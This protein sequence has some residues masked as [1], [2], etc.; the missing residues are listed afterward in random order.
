LAE[1]KK[2]GDAAATAKDSAQGEWATLLREFL[3][4][5]LLLRDVFGYALPGG[6]LVFLFVHAYGERL[7]SP[8]HG[9]MSPWLA[10]P[11]LLGV[12]IVSGQMAIALGYGLLSMFNVQLAWLKRRV[13]KDAFD[14][15]GTLDTIE[16][17]YYQTRYP[18]FFAEADHQA[19]ST[20]L[21]TGIAA[22]LLVGAGAYVWKLVWLSLFV[23]VFAGSRTLVAIR[24]GALG[25]AGLYMLA[26]AYEGL[27]ASRCE[28]AAAVIA[29]RHMH[30]GSVPDAMT[31][32]NQ[33]A[34]APAVPAP[35][36]S[37]SRPP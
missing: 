10:A 24:A 5:V 29:S 20:L 22:A 34:A 35:A 9:G 28:R 23:N 27:K 13:L 25:A 2:P 36:P 14:R 4:S 18:E 19:N 37:P 8:I 3:R 21:R 17:R 16:L 7:L 12:A 15:E 26:N 6:L 32:V 33:P 30:Q 11:V 1:E 31:V